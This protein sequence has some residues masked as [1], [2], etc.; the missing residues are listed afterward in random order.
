MMQQYQS[1]SYLFGGNAP[2][3]EEL[4]EA[5]LQNPA[6]VPDNWRAYFDAMQNVPAANGT[7]SRDI[8]HAPIVASF[9]ERAKQGPIRTIVASADADMGRKRVAATQLIA[10][11]RNIGSHWADLDP[12]KRQERPP[13]PDLDPA[14]YGFS[15]ADL[16]I[17]FN[18]SNTYFGKESMSLRELL[19][20]LRETYCSS[21]GAEFMYISDQAQ[22][23]W[24]QERLESTRARPVFT[25]EKK[26]HI[27]ERLTAAEGLER[28]L[29]TKYVGQ[30]RF[31]LEGGESFIAAMDEL[32]QRAGK[33]GVQEIVIGMA[34]RGRLNVLVNTLGKMPADLFAEF[35]GKHVDDLPAGDV[36][37]HKGFSS[38]VS[39]E[40]GPV[41]L[42]LAFNPSHLEIV[43]PVVEGSAKA[44]QERRGEAGHREVLPVQVHGDAAFAGQGV[45]METLNLAQTRGY[46][47]GGTMH[48][49]INNQIGFTTSDPRDARSTLYC[50]DVVKM[51]EAPVLHVNGD[52]PEAVVFAMQLAVDYRMEFK[53]DVV[54]D[55]ICFRKLGHNEQDTPAVTQPLMYKK[56]SQ[57]PGTRKVY[58]DKLATQNVVP[59]D[60][61]DELVKAYRAAMD[62]GKH[63][64]DPV[65]SNFKN[66]FAV[67]WMPFLNR[68]WT[69]AADTAVPVTELKRLA[70]RITTIPEQFKLH[71]LVEKVIKDRANMGRGDQ[72]LDWGMGEHLAF[73]SLV[74]S[75]Y[76][77]RITGQ[78]AGRG[79][80]THRHAVL[81]DQNRERW[82]AG[83]YVPL[84]NV[85]EGQAPFTVIDSVLSEEA[86]LGFEYGYST[87]EPNALV[88][89]EAQFGDFVNGAQ[90]VIDQFI[91]SGEVKWGRASGLTLMLPHG[92]EGQGPE[93]S[94]ARIERFLQLCADHNMQVCQPTTPAQIFHLL[95]RQMIRLFRKPLVIMTP[96]SLLR[97]KDAVSPLSD[98]AK[99]HF[100]TVIGE[101]EE[102]NASKVKR[103]IMCSGKVYY[104]LVATRKER[105]AS[106]VA[107]IR[108]EQLYPFPHKA[109][110]AELKKYPN[111][112]EIVWCQDEPQNQGAWFFV[113]HYIMENM[114]EGQKLGYAGRPASASPAV[115]YYAKHNEQQKALLD[116]AFSKLKGFVLSK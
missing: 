109:V 14:F 5:Y 103:V 12:L 31:S 38:D 112:T 57:H 3:V 36:K 82:D 102:L 96:K 25:A 114:T 39:T 68:K 76:P 32:I 10:A 58:A 72:P 86:V 15:E 6:S 2:Y 37:Y 50:T 55:I 52:D 33:Q 111:A 64:V 77:V 104:D 61:G 83:S 113:Q 80:F 87:A 1:N 34:H 54:V 16:D 24:W 22:K 63:T 105:G 47:T 51:I 81:H 56:I 9:A 20:N 62:A 29:H 100:E 23:R 74:A 116:A 13:L 84:Q 28:F 85:S 7:A 35:E 71:P 78:D 60:F 95:R 27:L 44:R 4:Y 92:Y 11:Y 18:A 69:D 101:Q 88:I 17:V 48:I 91:S 73:A 53:K 30:K 99:G 79:T 8:P 21:I 65:L 19:Q 115:G 70:E 40:G 93:H 106:D 26:K 107:V 67:D 43:N 97:N 108:L 42:S 66:K 49:V 90:V 98:L 89:W 45:V 46:G 59:A 75:G 41:H 94:S 110:A